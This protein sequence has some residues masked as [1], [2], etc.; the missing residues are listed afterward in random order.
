MSAKQIRKERVK[1]HDMNRAAK[2]Q[3]TL[4]SQATKFLLIRHGETSWNVE[5]RWQGQKDP[6][7]NQ[8]GEAQAEA[9]AERLKHDSAALIFSS[10][11]QRAAKTAFTIL[12]VQIKSRDEQGT[13]GTPPRT[14]MA[15]PD[16]RERS[17]GVLEGLT[18]A[19]VRVQQPEAWEALRSGDY[20]CR[21][22]GGESPADV[23]LRASQGLDEIA[24]Q[25]PGKTIIL[26]THGGVLQVL[27]RHATG[28]EYN[29][30]FENCAINVLWIDS[31][32]W[33][34]GVWGDLL[35]LEQSGVVVQ[36]EAFGGGT[37][38]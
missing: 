19:E 34:T 16:F 6:P 35:H 10:D 38:G 26:V 32:A 30:K 18:A 23:E 25:H 3:L 2:I 36:A 22:P 7:L 13:P 37:A 27:Y 31:G 29:G 4:T 15:L 5:H 33:K 11:L 9:L 14:V 8:L 24:R 20:N 28:R 21:V 17:L 12:D 1:M